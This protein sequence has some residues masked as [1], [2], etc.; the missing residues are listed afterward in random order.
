[1]QNMMDQFHDECPG[2]LID[3]RLL[4]VVDRTDTDGPCYLSFVPLT[5]INIADYFRIV[6]MRSK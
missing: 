2:V 3:Q 1:M 6:K 4:A 5:T